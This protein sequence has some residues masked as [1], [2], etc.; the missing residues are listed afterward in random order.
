MRRLTRWVR[1]YRTV[2]VLLFAGALLARVLQPA[3]FVTWDEPKWVFR[4]IRFVEA[5]AG[6]DLAGTFQAGHPGVT[7]MWCGVIGIGLR[8]LIEGQPV[9]QVL[10]TV[11]S[12]PSLNPFDAEAMRILAPF[13]PYGRLVVGTVTALC[14]AGMYLLAR[15]FVDD[16]VAF[17]ASA[18]VA[19]DPFC[20]AHSRVLHVDALAASFMVL[21]IFG[22][23]AHLATPRSRR[24]AVISGCSAGLA[25]LSKS[26]AVFLLPMV[27][28]AFL[29]ALVVSKNARERGFKT[30]LMDLAIWGICMEA[31]F[32]LLFP[33]M[34]VH[35]IDTL[36]GIGGV[37]GHHA[38]TPHETIFYR[39]TVGEDPGA[40]FYPH[41]LAFR[42]TPLVMV[43]LL[44]AIPSLAARQSQR[45]ERRSLCTVILSAVLFVSFMTFGAKKFDR[46]LLPLFPL[47]DLVAAVGYGGLMKLAARLLGAVLG[48]ESTDWRRWCC[49]SPVVLGTAAIVFLMGQ[50]SIPYS[51]YYLSYY[52]P[53]LGGGAAAAAEMPVGW[54]EGV[55][56]A[57]D[58]LNGL[59]DG[60]DPKVAT[61]AVAG[62]APLFDGQVVP[63]K[64][65]SVP[66]ADYILL[67]LGDVQA[68]SP[69]VQELSGQEP[70]HVV[71]LHGIDYAWIYPNLHYVELVDHIEA[72]SEVDDI[73][74]VNT[75]SA[76]S[77]HYDGALPVYVVEGDDASEV[78]TI[79]SQVAGGAR[80][81]WFL[82]YEDA[83]VDSTSWLKRQL[84]VYCFELSKREFAY[85]EL[86]GYAARPGTQY[87]KL[88]VDRDA[89]VDFERVI[90]LS[91]FGLSDRL[92]EYRRKLGVEL[93]WDVVGPMDQDYHLFI[94]LVDDNGVTWSQW[95]ERLLDEEGRPTSQWT[96]GA[97]VVGDHVLPLRPGTPPG[98]YQLK[99][100]FYL[101]DTLERL[102]ILDQEEGIPI[103]TE[104]C[105]S[106]VRVVD[107]TY[108]PKP[109]EFA[110]QHLLGHVFDDRIRLVGADIGEAVVRSG[111]TLH[112]ELYWQAL[113]PLGVDYELMIRLEDEGGHTLGMTRVSP[114]RTS[115]PTSVW[116]QGD[117][118]RYRQQIDITPEAAGGSYALMVNL[119][120]PDTGRPL[121]QD[122]VHVADV[123]VRARERL[124][125]V[126]AIMHPGE[127][128]FGDDIEFLGFDLTEQT[129]A[130]GDTIHLTIYW[131]A[132][133]PTSI[134]YTVFT[135]LLDEESKLVGQRDGVPVA[136]TRPTT[137]WAVGEVIIDEYDIVVDRDASQGHC[138]IEIGLYD[139]STADR[140][141]A[142]DGEGQRLPHD[143]VLLPISVEVI[144]AAQP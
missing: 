109:E 7:T 37:G 88:E 13:L 102:R 125:D 14:V 131:R 94:H 134:P 101:L 126:P 106:P 9:G 111:G 124:F 3:R 83:C 6:G 93:R 123:T 41:A 120:D 64:E 46:Y 91:G 59:G 35:P 119:V 58:Y 22:V 85:G 68:N 69:L 10:T 100:G 40:L 65:D 72:S 29:I 19:L 16:W 76:F 77:K 99:V 15:R 27:V 71:R 132:L 116:P 44:L 79:L 90:S 108:P 78:A 1:D 118:T 113:M 63:L 4:S 121:E 38:I 103:G 18:L 5:L 70:D 33:A 95:D 139:P 130:S 32:L 82:E 42:L 112:F 133:R 104:H 39:G 67:Y 52:N 144:V 128:R 97:T 75:A 84:D 17:L 34:W 20:L 96:A 105:L 114:S 142:F 31:V 107:A 60:G 23:L 24:Y 26:P 25:L 127:A 2:A 141:F 87:G 110:I 98:G 43:G 89:R 115:Y 136:G 61:W 28:L 135:H 56:L 11:S 73:V 66:S 122:D 62:L 137:G 54:G 45:A 117:I 12:W 53:W 50:T 21:S 51:P 57:A 55:E 129:V 8:R 140:M 49:R 143:R 36:M 74:V 47:L 86:H 30:L 138:L 81:I 48:R 92:M 80:R